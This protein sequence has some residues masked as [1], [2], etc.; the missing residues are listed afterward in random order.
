[1]TINKIFCNQIK[2]NLYNK[3]HRLLYKTYL[4]LFGLTDKNK[5]IEIELIIP[6]KQ[7]PT[8]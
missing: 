6:Q 2:C 8:N 7:K 3:T 5:N 4:L 1:M